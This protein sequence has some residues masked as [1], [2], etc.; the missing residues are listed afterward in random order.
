MK[1]TLKDMR[2]VLIG[3]ILLLMAACSTGSKS[4]SPATS[5]A[6]EFIGRWHSFEL[7][8]KDMGPH[9]KTVE[10]VFRSGGQFSAIGVMADEQKQVYSGRY[11][12][13]STALDLT[14]DRKSTESM[15]YTLS[16]GI[17]EIRDPKLDSYVKFQRSDA[18]R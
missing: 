6:R 15:P 4:P 18:G 8:G 17:L 14:V 3:A 7:G 1:R 12:V 10:Y 5:A 13:S 16:N 9:L 2:L 11:S